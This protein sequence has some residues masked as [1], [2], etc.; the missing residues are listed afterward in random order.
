MI[1]RTRWS[2]SLVYALAWSPDGNYLAFIASD[3]KLRIFAR[4]TW[5]VVQTLEDPTGLELQV[6][7]SPDG[8]YLACRANG[9]DF[10][11]FAVD[12]WRVIHTLQGRTRV[13]SPAWSPDSQYLAALDGTSFA[14]SDLVQIWAVETEALV[15][16][17]EREAIRTLTRVAWSPDGRYLAA[18]EGQAPAPRRITIWTTQT[19]EEVQRLVGHGSD[20]ISVRWSR[21]GNYLASAS[22]DRTLRLWIA[23]KAQLK[24]KPSPRSPHEKLPG[25]RTESH[26][27]HR[28]R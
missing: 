16:T 10:K 12:D 22:L 7:W 14:G 25:G 11:I 19:G 3:R 9:R 4:D 2:G 8:K 23:P 5:A 27:L 28:P 13:A 21:D 1:E 18:G 20:I 26:G 6:A 24:A 15:R 17:I